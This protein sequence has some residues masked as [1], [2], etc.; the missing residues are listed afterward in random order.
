MGNDREDVLVRE[1]SGYP[2]F[3]E[4]DEGEIRTLLQGA[5]VRRYN[6]ES[7]ILFKEGDKG[8]GLYLVLRGEVEIYKVDK[9]R[10]EFLLSVLPA[11]EFVGEMALLEEK[12]RSA[13][14]RAKGETLVLFI[15]RDDYHRFQKDHP[16]LISKLLLR[17]LSSVS[18]RLRLQSEHYVLT[19]GAFERLKSF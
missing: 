1:L 5:K 2:L 4:F 17:M 7:P 16:A 13:N 19:K 14:G 18:E 12:P 9:A 8:D 15:T 11:G 3:K 10:T 6:K